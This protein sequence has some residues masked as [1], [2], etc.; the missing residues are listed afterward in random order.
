MASRVRNRKRDD[1]VIAPS[2]SSSS[3]IGRNTNGSLPTTY[4][5]LLP[6]LLSPKKIKYIIMNV[7]VYR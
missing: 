5:V 4:A 1:D 2:R 3:A 6:L 7:I